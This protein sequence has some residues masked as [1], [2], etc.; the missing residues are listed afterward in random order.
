VYVSS[1]AWFTSHF[2]YT[3]IF[4]VTGVPKS[5][6]CVNTLSLYQPANVYPLFVGSV[7]GLV[8]VFPL[9]TVWLTTTLPPF[10]LKLTVY[11][12][13]SHTAYIVFVPLLTSTVEPILGV[14]AVALSAHPKNV[15]PVLVGFVVLTVNVWFFPV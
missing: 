10:V 14:V 9:S 13:I 7:S 5:Y 2:A 8:A 1:T 4:P 12:L 6:T 11:L 3:V 15:Y